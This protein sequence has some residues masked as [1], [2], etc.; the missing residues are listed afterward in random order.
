MPAFLNFYS[1]SGH[2][3]DYRYHKIRATI[4]YFDNVLNTRELDTHHP[5]LTPMDIDRLRGRCTIG[6]GGLFKHYSSL[7]L[8][9][10]ALPVFI[11][12]FSLLVT[13]DEAYMRNAGVGSRGV[14]VILISVL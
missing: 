13:S 11:V 9:K 7:V 6:A 4:I 14:T 2:Q 1:L 10:I 12:P 3:L 8:K 5:F